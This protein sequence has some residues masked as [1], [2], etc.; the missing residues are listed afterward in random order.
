MNNNFRIIK[1]THNVDGIFE[2]ISDG[3]PSNISQDNEV[4]KY[5][6]S[7]KM[8]SMQSI[9]ASLDQL[10]TYKHVEKDEFIL[11][12]IA[13]IL[14][15]VKKVSAELKITKTESQ[16]AKILEEFKKKHKKISD[17]EFCRQIDLTAP[18]KDRKPDINTSIWR[19]SKDTVFVNPEYSKATKSQQMAFTS[20]FRRKKVPMSE[21]IKAKINDSIEGNYTKLAIHKYEPE[22]LRYKTYTPE[23]YSGLSYY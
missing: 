19:T 12:K 18:K 14:A 4:L 2:D 21:D 17:G 3:M 1:K 10:E 6:K 22:R 5:I 11:N 15:E 13:V 16:K 20:A 8:D 9:E 23:G 7:I